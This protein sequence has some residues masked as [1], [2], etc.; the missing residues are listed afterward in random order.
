MTSIGRALTVALLAI[1]LLNTSCSE[2]SG[3]SVESYLGYWHRPLIHKTPIGKDLVSVSI[4][5]PKSSNQKTNDKDR[6]QYLREFAAANSLSTRGAK[7][8]TVDYH[9]VDP[10]KTEPQSLGMFLPTS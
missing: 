2:S 8:I 4:S 1:A 6:Q 10:E 5:L 9:Y 3:N 7:I